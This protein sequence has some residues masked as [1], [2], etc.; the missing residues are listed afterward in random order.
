MGMVY[1]SMFYLS[2]ILKDQFLER[3]FANEND[4]ILTFSSIRTAAD[5]WGVS[6]N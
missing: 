6:K 4:A 5:F 1:P 2:K 3:E